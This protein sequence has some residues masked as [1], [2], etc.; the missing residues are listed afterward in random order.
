[1]AHFTFQHPRAPCRTGTIL[2]RYARHVLTRTAP[3][4]LRPRLRLSNNLAGNSMRIGPSSNFNNRQRRR[5]VFEQV[6]EYVAS[7]WSMEHDK[8]LLTITNDGS[9]AKGPQSGDIVDKSSP[10]IKESLKVQVGRI[11]G[12][13][14]CDDGDGYLVICG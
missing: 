14:D 10:S 13:N 8:S 1:M 12:I 5:P 7:G 9:G 3:Q 2:I 11:D 6:N 4:Y